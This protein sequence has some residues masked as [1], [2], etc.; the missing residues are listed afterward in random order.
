MIYFSDTDL[1]D[2]YIVHDEIVTS[3]S[4]TKLA[5]IEDPSESED[6][7]SSGTEQSDTAKSDET[8]ENDQIDENK[9]IIGSKSKNFEERDL[10]N[11]RKVIYSLWFEYKN[12]DY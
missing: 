12:C 2:S 6:V 10:N 3:G 5:E 8:N 9:N 4:L 1:D 11:N 7:T